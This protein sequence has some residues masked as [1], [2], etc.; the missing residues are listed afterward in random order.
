MPKYNDRILNTV[1]KIS[2]MENRC[3]YPCFLSFASVMGYNENIHL[4]GLI[5]IKFT[6]PS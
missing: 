5:K 6:A 4:R 2:R 3:F 1:D